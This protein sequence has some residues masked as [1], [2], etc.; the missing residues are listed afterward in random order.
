MSTNVRERLRTAL[1][2]A[3][4]QRD[5]ELVAVL[6]ATLAALDNAEAVPHRQRDRGSLALEAIPLGVGTQ[7][8]T[9]RAL[10]DE[11]MDRLVRG[12]ISDRREAARVYEQAG[13]H[14]RARRLR[15]EADLLTEAA[16]LPREPGPP[17]GQ[18]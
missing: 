8:V 9:R 1:P 2:A 6:R 18:R 15:Q 10:S 17:V 7:E 13:E 4:K 14:G 5:S 12:E 11:D 16:G 3:L